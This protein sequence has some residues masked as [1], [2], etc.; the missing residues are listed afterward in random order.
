M[1]IK[2]ILAFIG[3]AAVSTMALAAPVSVSNDG[4]TVLVAGNASPLVRLTPNQVV[5]AQ[6][7]FRMTDGRTLTLTG[8]GRRMYMEL[9]GKREELLP[10][11]RTRFVGRDTGS[12]LILDDLAF[13]DK[14]RLIQAR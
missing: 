8:Q 12:E 6:G 10:T 9:D 11:S 1:R 5:D 7:S 13:P 14:V 2:H 4:S 3:A